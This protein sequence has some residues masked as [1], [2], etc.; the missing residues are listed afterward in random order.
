MQGIGHE[1]CSIKDLMQRMGLKDRPSFMN[2]YLSPAIA[3]GY[4]RMLYPESPRHPRQKYLLTIKGKGLY[5]GLRERESK[6]TGI[7]DSQ[8]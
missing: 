1:E 8:A 7:S 2:V 3:E 5:S 4:V 6:G